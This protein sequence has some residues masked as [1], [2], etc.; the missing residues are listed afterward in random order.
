MPRLS[1]TCGTEPENDPETRRSAAAL[2]EHRELGWTE[3]AIFKL[4]VAR[5]DA[6]RF[7]GPEIA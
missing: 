7:D 1:V 6:N 2:R 4:I 3:G 5:L